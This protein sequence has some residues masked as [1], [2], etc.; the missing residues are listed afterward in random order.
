[1]LSRQQLIDRLRGNMPPATTM[2]IERKPPSRGIFPIID[3]RAP[4]KRGP[5]KREPP[6]RGIFPID[7]IPPPPRRGGPVRP[8]RE[9]IGL[10]P[11]F[12]YAGITPIVGEG[13]RKRR[14]KKH[15]EE[16]ELEGG[17]LG[18]LL[19][20]GARL[21][22][23]AA[24]VGSTA[25]RSAARV[26][27]SVGRTAAKPTSTALIPYNAANAARAAAAARSAATA[28][29]AARTTGTLG[30]RIASVG[31]RALTVGNVAGIGLGVGLPIY[32]LVSM[33]KQEAEYQREMEKAAREG[34]AQAA[35]NLRISKQNEKAIQDAIDAAEAQ[36]TFYEE[37]GKL[38]ASDRARQ[39]ADYNKAV[40][41][42]QKAFEDQARRD[43]QA[44]ADAQRYQQEQIALL[45]QMEQERTAALRATLEQQLAGLYRP[46][47]PAPPP[48]T[49]PSRPSA[50]APPPS[51]P[52]PPP[53]GPAPPPSRGKPRVG[54]GKKKVHYESED[55]IE[56]GN[57]AA[58]FVK[59]MLGEVKAK[60]KGTYKKPTK[61]I[62]K[63]TEMNAPVAF[64]YF[65]LPSHSREKSPF[66]MSH[67]LPS[68]FNRGEREELNEKELK[69]L[70]DREAER[71][72]KS[73][74]NR[75]AKK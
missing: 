73:R 15:H 6:S 68:T 61:P 55:E 35:E 40:A 20:L 9:L 38:A 49:T 10:T 41:D 22:S 60:H 13:K 51:A 58:G 23:T 72:R 7:R 3:D 44:V 18:S 56:G 31:S 8:P 59:R 26:L 75:K 70:R 67:F 57:Q 12:S 36:K 19:S 32:Q 48:P 17:F 46:S 47:A 16:E 5:P 30:S 4:P 42:A 52:A 1:M 54:N 37:Q 14:S 2:P 45:Y 63:G 27:P 71:Q 24:R 39:E 53:S 50:P 65:S 66:I 74:A 43:A 21:G 33:K 69:I 29:A 11:D 28:S 25:A 64:D 62:R 34:D